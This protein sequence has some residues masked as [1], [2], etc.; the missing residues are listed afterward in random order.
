MAKSPV[1]QLRQIRIAWNDWITAVADLKQAELEEYLEKPK[2]NDSGLASFIFLIVFLIA[3]PLI[4]YWLANWI[5][6]GLGMILNFLS[7]LSKQKQD[8][9]SDRLN[10]KYHHKKRIAAV[11]HRFIFGWKINSSADVF[12]RDLAPWA[13]PEQPSE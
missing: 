13:F 11:T 4:G 8:E 5:G 7:V 1:E 10:E 9:I 2:A 12:Q 3:F 6:L